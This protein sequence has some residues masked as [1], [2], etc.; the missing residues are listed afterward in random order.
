MATYV[1][2]DDN[3]DV[4]TTIPTTTTA[5]SDRVTLIPQSIVNVFSFPAFMAEAAPAAFKVHPGMAGGMRG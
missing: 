5:Y 1:G 2:S 4:R 3:G